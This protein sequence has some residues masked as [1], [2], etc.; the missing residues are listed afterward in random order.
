MK[1]LKTIKFPGLDDTYYVPEYDLTPY[2]TQEYV[3]E[4]IEAIE[5]LQGPQGEPGADGEDYVLTDAD[6]AEIAGMVDVSNY[7]TKSEVEQLI[8]SSIPASGEEVSY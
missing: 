3:D 4:Q 2:A 6:K 5:L 7:Y 1:Q 8:A